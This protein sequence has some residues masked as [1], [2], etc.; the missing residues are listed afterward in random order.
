LRGVITIG[1]TLTP[2]RKEAIAGYFRAGI[3]NRY[4]LRE[5]GCWSGQNCPESP[6]S[7]H[8][9]TE[10]VALE[11]L[12][13]DGTPAAPGETGKVVLTDLHNRVMPMIRYDTGDLAVAG[14]EEPCPCGRGFP[15]MGAVEGRSVECVVTPSGRTV[16]AIVLG[17]YFRDGGPMF[18][19]KDHIRFMRHYQVIQEGLNE[20]RLLVVPENGFDETRARLLIRDVERLLGGEMRVAVDTVTEIPLEKSGKRPLIK[21]RTQAAGQTV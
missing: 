5:F 2:A 16:S 14:P 1:E 18:E 15:L 9:N 8:I 12:K 21:G 6:D 17:R 4:G 11:I 19:R 13:N 7:F 20:V 3:I 10:L